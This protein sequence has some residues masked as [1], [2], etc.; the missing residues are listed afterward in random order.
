MP[1]QLME[2][3]DH[4]AHFNKSID[5][6]A[7]PSYEFGVKPTLWHGAPGSGMTSLRKAFE[8]EVIDRIRNKQHYAFASVSF[9]PDTSL[10]DLLLSIRVQLSTF[11]KFDFFTFDWA[12]IRMFRIAHPD[13]DIR[14]THPNLFTKS[15]SSA[16]DDIIN[17]LDNIGRDWFQGAVDASLTL[18]PG[19][20]LIKDAM[21]GTRRVV[22]KR[23]EE[24]K[25][26]EFIDRVDALGDEEIRQRL[27][28]FLSEAIQRHQEAQEKAKSPL[29]VILFVDG[30]E[31]L[32]TAAD[33][34]SAKA[35]WLR[36]LSGYHRTFVNVFGR[37]P[38]DS[39]GGMILEPRY[40]HPLQRGTVIQFATRSGLQ[41]FAAETLANYAQGN[42]AALVAGVACYHAHADFLTGP[43]I[44]SSNDDMRRSLFELEL[45]RDVSPRI[46]RR[47]VR[48]MSL[49]TL[50]ETIFL[51]CVGLCTDE[52]LARGAKEVLGVRSFDDPSLARRHG[53]I[54]EMS[55]PLQG[56][57]RMSSFF[58]G[59][60][61]DNIPDHIDTSLSVK[62]RSAEWL[63]SEAIE[64]V[65]ADFNQASSAGA[66]IEHAVRLISIWD[67]QIFTA[68]EVLMNTTLK[69]G[70][71]ALA[72]RM[73]S[74]ILQ[75]VV[76]TQD[77]M[78]G[79]GLV[80]TAEVIRR[81]HAI[82][83]IAADD[84]KRHQLAA[85]HALIVCDASDLPYGARADMATRAARSAILCKTDD[86]LTAALKVRFD[87]VVESIQTLATAFLTG[88][89]QGLSNEDH[90]VSELIFIQNQGD[91]EEYAVLEKT[92]LIIGIEDKVRSNLSLTGG[93]Y[94]AQ[95][96]LL[97]MLVSM[98]DAWLNFKNDMVYI[99]DAFMLCGHTST[100]VIDL[101][102]FLV[103]I[104]M[105]RARTA[106][107]EPTSLD[108]IL[109][110]KGT[111]TDY[112]AE[113]KT[114]L[115]L[116]ALQ[117][118]E[119]LLEKIYL[120]SEMIELGLDIEE[121]RKAY[122]GVALEVEKEI[123]RSGYAEKPFAD[124][125]RIAEFMIDFAQVLLDGGAL[126]EAVTGKVVTAIHHLNYANSEFVSPHLYVG[127][128]KR[129]QLLEIG[130]C[131]GLELGVAG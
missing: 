78:S 71:A 103:D 63:L 108:F 82:M 9:V 102:T 123:A 126:K 26:R 20:K 89:R 79:L 60:L 125:A 1:F 11:R 87:D 46:Y 106:D 36:H 45:K 49:A 68:Y 17:W 88:E 112:P 4:F 16:A 69:S 130:R 7:D 104:E 66:N 72:Y 77:T 128:V 52:M 24:K 86:L 107:E 75:D 94:A 8:T 33:E 109:Q 3:E 37:S 76:D 97:T 129:E 28:E 85:S 99:L 22:L 105:F 70:N 50:R 23:I 131:V 127:N 35:R 39:V 101:T 115:V 111:K 58:R 51:S 48:D 73:G 59:V 92:R 84:M 116:A 65:E 25:N 124:H 19:A 21:T 29:G 32:L 118:S 44:I 98:R 30:Y 95:R 117:T 81:A 41:P 31:N 10:I 120:L 55:G 47:L 80:P 18:V 96:R 90:I 53:L 40:L 42:P 13:K 113:F 62:R 122:L 15:G 74:L 38:M 119:D 2:R 114:K 61:F 54:V 12:F 83:N 67:E 5:L 6:L 100:A 91:G 27:P 121:E 56:G 34:Q 64:V 57:G 43:Y 14:A 110:M 93:H